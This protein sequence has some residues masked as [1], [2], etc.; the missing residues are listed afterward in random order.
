METT[1]CGRCGSEGAYF[2]GL[3]YECP[4]CGFKFGAIELEEDFD[5]LDED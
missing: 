4:D 1:E 3:E 2:N 5:E